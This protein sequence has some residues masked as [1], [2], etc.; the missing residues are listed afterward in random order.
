MSSNLL[1]ND[2]KGKLQALISENQTYRER[3]AELDKQVKKLG[4]KLAKFEGQEEQLSQARGKITS[5]QESH[6]M[7]VQ[8]L[9]G[10]ESELIE[11]K[12]TVNNLQRALQQK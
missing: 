11:V 1:L 4:K 12:I 9:D 6:K 3:I 2:Q 10:K 8:H 5:L 7:Q